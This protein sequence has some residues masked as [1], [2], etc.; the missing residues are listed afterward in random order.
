MVLVIVLGVLGFYDGLR[1]RA[2]ANRELAQEHYALGLAHL[3]SDDYELAIAEF[4]LAKRYD[5]N[6]GGLSERLREAKELARS[7]IRPTS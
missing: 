4:E 2:M 3:E 1:D 7:Q 5:S 6:L